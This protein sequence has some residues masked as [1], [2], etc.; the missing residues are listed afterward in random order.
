MRGVS[1]VK[2]VIC[3]LT[4]CGCVC[5]I[6]V[7]RRDFMPSEG[8]ASRCVCINDSE[9]EHTGVCGSMHVNGVSACLC[10]CTHL[11]VGEIGVDLRAP[12]GL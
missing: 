10:V 4:V 11:M 2:Q 9:R 12:L 3:S 5:T 8:Q 6:C 7:H 1:D